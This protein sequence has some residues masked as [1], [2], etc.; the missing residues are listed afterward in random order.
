MNGKPWTPE[1]LERL[2]RLYPDTPT[3]DVAKACEH[4]LSNTYAKATKLGLKKSAAFN[5]S[6]ASGRIEHRPSCGAKYR[7]PK[8]H[9]PLNKGL[10]RPGWYRGRMRETQFK[11]GQRPHT[12]VPIGTEVERKDG[13]IWVKVTDD[14]KPARRNWISKNRHVYEA[15]HGRI[16]PK[17]IV[18]F[19]DGDKRNFA[20]EN[21]ECIS[22]RDN[23]LRNSIHRYPKD[24]VQL[25]Q[26]RGAINRQI[27]RR[28]P[29]PKARIGRPPKQKATEAPA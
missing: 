4:T 16:P 26:L 5:A 24:I 11:K 6:P 25:V 1:L 28:R 20:L 14:V 23:A 3:R 2:R 27:N 15:A 7:Y 29:R 21:L 19:K 8:G 10:R 17:H 18:T 13:Y 22:K 12:E 9:V